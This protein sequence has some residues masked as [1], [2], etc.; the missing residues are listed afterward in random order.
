[1]VPVALGDPQHA[2]NCVFFISQSIIMLKKQALLISVLTK[3]SKNFDFSVREK[4][5]YESWEKG[6]FFN[7]D[8]TSLKPSYSLLMPPP[9]LTGDLHLGHAMQHSILDAIA[10]TAPRIVAL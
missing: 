10:T 5:I 6:G 1:M 4:E 8:P 3:V 7:A 9:N 2:S